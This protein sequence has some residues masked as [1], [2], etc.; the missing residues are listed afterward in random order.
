MV[1]ERK[2]IKSMLTH[3]Q[4]WEYMMKLDKQVVDLLRGREKRT[5]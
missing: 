2:D 3:K 5:L 1:I 4:G